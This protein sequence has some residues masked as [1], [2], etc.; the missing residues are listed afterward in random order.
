[1]EALASAIALC[2]KERKVCLPLEINFQNMMER[3]TC[4]YFF[5][6]CECVSDDRVANA[7]DIVNNN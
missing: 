2:R 4:T 7:P 6:S 1:M 3:N 5:I